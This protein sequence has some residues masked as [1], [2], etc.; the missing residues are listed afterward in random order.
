MDSRLENTSRIAIEPD[1]LELEDVTIEHYSNHLPTATFDRL[2]VRLAE[3]QG[4]AF[5]G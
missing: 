1:I 3:V 4:F 5:G 2:F